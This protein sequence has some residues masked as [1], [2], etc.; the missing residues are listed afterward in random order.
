[1]QHID[2]VNGFR[3]DRNTAECG[4]PRLTSDIQWATLYGRDWSG[5]T[6]RSSGLSQTSQLP[7]GHGRLQTAA[8]LD[9]ISQWYPPQATTSQNERSVCAI[10]YRYIHTKFIN[11]RKQWVLFLQEKQRPYKHFTPCNLRTYASFKVLYVDHKTCR[12]THSRA[13][14]HIL[15]VECISVV[16][17]Q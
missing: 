11:F 10:G 16:Q 7:A 8:T 9:W 17:S 5:K 12:Y 15:V 13:H 3:S 1:M 2:V 4:L 6:P 14:P